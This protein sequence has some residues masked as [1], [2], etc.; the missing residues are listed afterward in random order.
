MATQNQNYTFD[1]QLYDPVSRYR[2]N[3]T[4]SDLAKAGVYVPLYALG[5]AWADAINR[6]QADKEVRLAAQDALGQQTM[7]TAQE[8][9]GANVAKA[10]VNNSIAGDAP[11]FDG[12]P[13]TVTGAD[14]KAYTYTPGEW[15]PV[16]FSNIAQRTA[17]PEQAPT[18]APSILSWQP[19]QQGQP[20]YFPMTQPTAQEAPA[21]E[22][23]TMTAE[24]P[25]LA[26]EA[27]A[28]NAAAPAMEYPA[29]ME[30]AGQSLLDPKTAPVYTPSQT[31]PS[32]GA[33]TMEYGG[34]PIDIAG[35]TPSQAKTPQKTTLEKMQAD[36]NSYDPVAEE[37]KKKERIAQWQTRLNQGWIQ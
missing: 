18:Q 31:A 13:V 32:A 3:T 5:S 33:P 21:E 7:P 14:G 9:N 34:L 28:E 30:Q 27:P 36:I 22:Q 24:A 10:I 25:T 26:Y 11:A 2:R 4:F 16:S 1:N 35:Y 29:Q 12:T 37:A 6:R 23:P 19:T 17:T 15:N 8:A 20:D